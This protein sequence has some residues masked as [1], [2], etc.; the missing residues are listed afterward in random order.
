MNNDTQQVGPLPGTI[1]SLLAQIEILPDSEQRRLYAVLGA[2]LGERTVQTSPLD[3]S[4]NAAEPDGDLAEVEQVRAW[5]EG[6]G[7]LTE[8]ERV[9]LI[10]EALNEVNAKEAREYLLARRKDVL[11]EKPSVSVRVAVTRMAADQPLLVIGAIVGAV[12]G[13]FT[14]ASG[15][16]WIWF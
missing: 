5:Y 6:L 9:G 10:D 7:E 1:G 16:F 12:L 11:D 13:I 8:Y 15:L 14:F 2:L 3:P 4:S